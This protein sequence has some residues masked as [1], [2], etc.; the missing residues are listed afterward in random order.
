M[1]IYYSDKL[2]LPNPPDL[3][4]FSDWLFYGFCI[5]GVG[6]AVFY[7]FTLYADRRQTSE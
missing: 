3:S 5:A 4:A 2:N 6:F 7:G 1:N